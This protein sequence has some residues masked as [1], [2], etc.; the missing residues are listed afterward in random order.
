MAETN[1]DT[2]PRPPL[3]FAQV[4]GILD[5]VLKR[6]AEERAAFLQERC[7][8]DEALRAELESLLAFTTD[9]RLVTGGARHM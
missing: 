5:E 9:G 1:R 7:A 3:S 6:P 4:E 2:T 8:G